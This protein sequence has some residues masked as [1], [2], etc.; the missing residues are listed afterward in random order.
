ME[1]IETDIAGVFILKPQIFHDE[2]GHFME[3][4]RHN[5][6]TAHIGE[7]DFVQDN[8]S[9]S[10]Y[11][12][13]RGLHFQNM[14][15][16]QSKLVRCTQGAVQDVAVDLREGSPTF[17]KHISIILRADE[18]TQFFI[19][20]GFAHGFAVLSEKATFQYKCDAY[21]HPQA[22]GGINPFDPQL[23]IKWLIDPK[24]AILSDK[25]LRNPNL[26]ELI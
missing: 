3:T 12:V 22:E 21:Y 17:G 25:D 9:S 15:H 24:D 7:V 26:S 18:G 2:R 16:A 10:S 13:I 8:E 4:Y 20:R 11:G 5:D 23:G 14:P 1:Y 6:F 19:P